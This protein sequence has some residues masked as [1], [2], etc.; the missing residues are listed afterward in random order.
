LRG[1]SG[2]A[3]LA[4]VVS[5]LTVKRFVAAIH[6]LAGVLAVAL[7]L[8]ELLA[9]HGAF[10]EALHQGGKT[11]SNCCVLCLFAKGQVDSPQ[12]GPIV[13]AFVRFS[14][15]QAP[16]LKSIVRTD[17]AYLAFPSRAPPALLT[18]QSVLA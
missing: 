18:L 1:G 8:F 15:D 7:L 6:V 12:S 10:H 5:R 16:L 4:L 13:T 9:A 14:V 3:L 2:Y 11:A 17:V